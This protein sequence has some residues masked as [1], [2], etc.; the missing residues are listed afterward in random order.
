MKKSILLVLALTSTSAFAAEGLVKCAIQKNNESTLIEIS[1]SQIKTIQNENLVGTVQVMD[2]R[3]I[4]VMI[5]DKEAYIM[6]QEDPRTLRETGSGKAFIQDLKTG[7]SLDIKC[8]TE[9]LDEA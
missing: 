4:Q 1:R 3:L 6:T 7:R 2:G 8:L 9:N 5:E